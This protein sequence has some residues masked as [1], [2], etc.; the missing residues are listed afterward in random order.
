MK[1][2]CE[3]KAREIERNRN[4]KKRMKIVNEKKPKLL[5]KTLFFFS[6]FILKF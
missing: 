1:E 5:N 3:K 6:I 2:N 4:K